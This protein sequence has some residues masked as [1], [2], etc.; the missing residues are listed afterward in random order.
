MKQFTIR[1]TWDSD[2]LADGHHTE[3][4]VK[5]FEGGVVLEVDAPF[6]NDPPSPDV[7]AGERCWQLWDYE[8]VEAFFL[9]KDE[10]YL[11]IELCP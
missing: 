5:G 8:V 11:E 4:T 3:I 2:P 6:Y 9:G 10:Q 1:S 7:G